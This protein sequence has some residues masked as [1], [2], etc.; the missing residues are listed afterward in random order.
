[1][2]LR[3]RFILLNLL[4]VLITVSLTGLITYQIIRANLLS[5]ARRESLHAAEDLALRIGDQ[6][7]A[8]AQVPAL[9]GTL[10]LSRYADAET[11]YQELDSIVPAMLARTDLFNL[12]VF[13]EPGVIAERPYAL[14]WHVRELSGAIRAL[15]PNIP[16]NPG[17]NP[18]RPV[19]D[20][21]RQEWYIVGRAVPGLVWTEPYFDA[22]GADIPMVTATVP[23]YD[24]ARLI[25]VATTDV[26]LEKVRSLFALAQL[27]PNSY[28]MLISAQGQVIAHQ[29]Q[30]ELELNETIAEAA[31]RL[32]SDD[33]DRLEAELKSGLDGVLPMHDPWTGAEAWAAYAVVPVTGWY[34]V[35]VTPVTDALAPVAVL[36]RVFLFGAV[37]LLIVLTGLNWMVMTWFVRPVAIL[38]GAVEQ[39]A[40]GERGELSLPIRRRDELG[41][42]ARSFEHMAGEIARGQSMLEA[43]VAAR[44]RELQVSLAAQRDQADALKATLDEVQR[45]R[46]LVAALSTPVIPLRRDTLVVPIIGTFDAE[47]AGQLITTTLTAIEQ[48]RTR[49]VILDVTGLPVLDVAA[50]QLLL[51][52]ADAA[53][54]L[55][56]CVLLVGISPEV[57]QTMVGL[58]L[59][60][61]N[62]RTLGT[63][64]AAVA[65]IIR[66][67]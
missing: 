63:L 29:R 46:A 54:L 7:A 3:L 53:R 6:L 28:V 22:G 52:L 35:I 51:R 42:L 47:R 11:Y 27:T 66:A 61:G 62:L 39:V 14:V 31:A 23:V 60:L 25:G 56:A 58:S 30:P 17:Y 18:A 41:R 64:E 26:P 40:R 16:G 21:P 1:M 50:A 67:G 37:V 38:T 57:A 24:D 44:T 49:Y 34:A 65:T 13:F 59:D 5:A 10:S 4:P 55:D 36:Q 2:S 12:G 20:Y 45:Q 8:D 9:L 43:A 19:Y 32:K 15:S 48:R 33:L